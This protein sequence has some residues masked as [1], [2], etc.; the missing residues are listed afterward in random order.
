M[1][2]YNISTSADNEIFL[3][4][5]RIIEKQIKNI[6]KEQDIIDVDGSIIRKYVTSDMK[7][8]KVF[9]NYDVDAVYVDS[10]VELVF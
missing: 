6:K 9:N 10:E 2:S 3:N 1:F 4:T 8:I 7:S 5:C